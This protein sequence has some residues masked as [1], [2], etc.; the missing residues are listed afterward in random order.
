VERSDPTPPEPKAAGKIGHMM[1]LEKNNL[2]IA[3]FI[4]GW[5]TAHICS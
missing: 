4:D 5:L 2:E 1:M 3:A